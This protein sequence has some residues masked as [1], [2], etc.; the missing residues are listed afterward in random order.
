M[1]SD[2][3]LPVLVVD[4]EEIALALVSRLLMRIGFEE[5][6]RAPNGVV[7]RDMLQARKYGLVICDWNMPEMNG[8]DLLKIIRASDRWKR[9]PFLMTSIDGSLERVKIARLA[10]V[11]AFLLKPFDETKLRTKLEEVLVGP[12]PKRKTPLT[13]MQPA[14]FAEPAGRAAAAAV[15]LYSTSG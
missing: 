1:F 8:L 12:L 10:G 4:D 6:D 13:P 11:S 2:S 7:A 9:I 5:I 14:G 15:K 3:P